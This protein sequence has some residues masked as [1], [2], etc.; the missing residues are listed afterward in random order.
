LD[1]IASP[2]YDGGRSV[3]NR[4]FWFSSF[5]FEEAPQGDYR[6]CFHDI[7]LVSELCFCRSHPHPFLCIGTHA[8]PPRHMKDYHASPCLS[9]HFP[10][11]GS[12]P[13]DIQETADT[14]KTRCR[15]PPGPAL[16]GLGDIKRFPAQS[17][18]FRRGQICCRF[19]PRRSLHSQMGP[20]SRA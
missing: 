12:C 7:R 9:S 1:R 15:K 4:I 2:D 5:P 3:K 14:M 10:R 19:Q 18:I 6:N 20:R 8:R 13:A 17:Q 16:R 11:K